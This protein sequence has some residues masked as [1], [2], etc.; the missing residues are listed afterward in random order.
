MAKALNLFMYFHWPFLVFLLAVLLR[1]IPFADVVVDTLLKW[2]FVYYVMCAP[3]LWKFII[4]E[5]KEG[6]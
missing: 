3:M 2:V 5:Y 1:V 6:K 4:A